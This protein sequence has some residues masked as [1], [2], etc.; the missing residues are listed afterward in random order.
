MR[1]GI[2]EAGDSRP[3]VRDER[4]IRRAAA[5]ARKAWARRSDGILGLAAHRGLDD[6]RP[7]AASTGTERTPA[8]SAVA[9]DL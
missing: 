1:L 3:K 5:P 4:P 7:P 2:A 8:T 9:K 6:S